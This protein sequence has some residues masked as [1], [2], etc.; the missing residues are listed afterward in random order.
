[1]ETVTI[2]ID[3]KWV[4]LVRSPLYWIVAALQG[5]SITFAPLFLYWSG[6]G[7]FRGSRMAYRA[8]LLRCLFSWSAVLSAARQRSNRRIEEE[9]S[10][11][12][13]PGR[14]PQTAVQAV[15]LAITRTKRYR[16]AL[17]LNHDRSREVR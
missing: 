1:M 10:P 5:V 8:V 9:K 17:Q 14:H 13:R 3:S 2:E 4:K 7:I 15:I 12:I 16:S 11:L 6:K